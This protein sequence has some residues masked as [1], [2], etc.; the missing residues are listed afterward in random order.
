MDEAS[1]QYTAFTV[2]SLG[3]FECEHM[4]FGLCN[5][6]VDRLGF[7]G[8]KPMLFRGFNVVK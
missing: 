5:T 4:L 7:T 2:G 1:K 3:F 6:P 8:P